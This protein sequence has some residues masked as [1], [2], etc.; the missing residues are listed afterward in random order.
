[1]KNGQENTL[2]RKIIETFHSFPFRSFAFFSLS[3]QKKRKKLRHNCLDL[4]R[5]INK[6]PLL[7]GIWFLSYIV[8]WPEGRAQNK[9]WHVC[10]PMLLG[11]ST[12][13]FACYLWRIFC[14]QFFLRKKKVFFLIVSSGVCGSCASFNNKKTRT[15]PLNLS[16]FCSFQNC[17]LDLVA[18]LGVETKLRVPCKYLLKSNTIQK[19]LKHRRHGVLG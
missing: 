1:M 8:R 16:F 10:G 11:F 13:C 9:L 4:I 14:L 17:S 18:S 12:P 6:L 7:S 3:Q 5:R 2:G 19:L 15:I